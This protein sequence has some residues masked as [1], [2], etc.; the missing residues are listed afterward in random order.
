MLRGKC[1][2]SGAPTRSRLNDHDN[3]ESRL[4]MGAPN[5][6][7]RNVRGNA[8]SMRRNARGPPRASPRA[9]PPVAVRFHLC[10]FH[11]HYPIA[12]FYAKKVNGKMQKK[13]FLD[14]FS[15]SD[16]GSASVPLAVGCVP[17]PTSLQ[18]PSQ[19]SRAGRNVFGGTPNT[20]TG[21]VALP[22]PCILRKDPLIISSKQKE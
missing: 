10:L 21:T 3:S 15:G 19:E 8:Q 6:K 4:K 13:G 7:A 9:L 22:N 2:Q 17:R 11:A 16:P 20:A 1:R 5:R 14:V 12:S 18:A